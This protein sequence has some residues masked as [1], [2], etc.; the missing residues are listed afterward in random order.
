[1]Y[2]LFMVMCFLVNGE[3]ECTNYDDST[4]KVY[5][6]L[7]KC[8]QDAAFRFYSMTDVFARFDQPYEKI[9]IGCMEEE[10]NL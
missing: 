7:S 5:E 6:E 2:K 1:M 10:S 8:E 9:E 3:V 4:G